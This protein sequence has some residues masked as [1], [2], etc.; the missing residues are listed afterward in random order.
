MLTEFDAQSLPLCTADDCRKSPC[1]A[2]AC[3][4]IYGSL[5]QPTTT[6]VSPLLVLVRLSY[7]K[8]R[9]HLRYKRIMLLNANILKR[10]VTK[11]QHSR[12][13]CQVE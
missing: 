13:Q 1:F 12:E 9:K 4:V 8:I 2:T 6:Y 7:R 3:L 11:T 5:I 10:F